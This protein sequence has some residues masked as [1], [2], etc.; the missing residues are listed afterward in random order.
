[1]IDVHLEELLKKYTVIDTH[2]H[3]GN[4][5]PH[6]EFYIDDNKQI[7]IYKKFNFRYVIG[8]HMANIYAMDYGT[9]KL[10]EIIDRFKGFVYGLMIFNP[11]CEVESLKIIKEHIDKKEIVG[12]KIHPSLYSCYPED[13][14][15]LKFCEFADENELVI[16]TH[17]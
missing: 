8:S 10:L 14:K 13:I 5:T 1:M 4:T 17:S 11:N 12:I 7:E 3:P 2:F 9:E 16:L 15:Y 6:G